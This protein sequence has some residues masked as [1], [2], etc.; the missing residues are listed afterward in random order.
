MKRTVYISLM[1]LSVALSISAQGLRH[2]VCIVEPEFNTED[3]ELMGDYALYMARAGFRSAARALTAYKS[4]GTFGSGVVVSNE[5]KRYVLTNLHVVGYAQKATISFQLHDKTLRYPHCPIVQ[6][7]KCDLAMLE[8]PA[9]C[10]MI[11][12]PLYTETIEEDM[13]IVA[14]GFP[15]LADKPSWP[16]TR[17]FISNAN[18]DLEKRENATRIIQ[19]SAS[20]DPG[21]SGG[22]LLY[23]D[24]EGKYSIMGINTWKAFYRDGVGMAIGKEDIQ[25]FMNSFS[26]SSA[27]EHDDLE[28]IHSMTGENWLYVFKQLPDS[29]QNK[30]KEMEWRLPLDQAL[31]TLAIRDSLVKNN[32]KKAKQYE[33]AA[34]HIVTDLDNNFSI[35]LMYDNYLGMNQQVGLVFG[36]EWLG[37]VSTGIHVSAL[38]VNAMKRDDYGYTIENKNCAGVL[39][40]ATFGVQVPIAVGKYILAPRITESASA[41]PVKTG[42]Y[43]GGFAVLSD[44]RAGLDFHL[45][46]TSYDLVLGVHYDMNWLWSKDDLSITP[47][48]DTGTLNQYLQHGL[49]I[50]VGIS[51]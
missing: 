32:S 34:T 16:L 11:A 31:R 48:K 25:E 20:I 9:D 3:K 44:T 47:Y 10:E 4:E 12:L 6:T 38:V 8:L 40:G 23:K 22:P 41:G 37:F 21:S 28:K 13:S 33:R 24:A 49:G 7:G 5:D 35:N 36:Q 43:N 46:F 27:T 30:L 39:F 50:T 45:P 51:W 29:T 15:E 1:L 2:S 17:G 26:T 42:Y 19:H 14:A 18:L